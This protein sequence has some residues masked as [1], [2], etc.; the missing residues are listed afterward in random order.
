M[1]KR[2]YPLEQI[3]EIKKRRLEE[4]EKVL[5]EKRLALDNAEKDLQ[6]KRDALNASLQLK[7]DLIEKHFKE[8]EKGTTSDV[9]ERHNRY[10]QEVI[11]VKLA[12]EKKKV[13]DQKKVVKDAKLALEKARDIR[14]KK[15]QEM[16]KINIHKK[17]WTK[18]AVKEQEIEEAGIADELGTSMH[19]RKM[20][21]RVR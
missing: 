15:N 21:K 16:E 18:E 11:E 4:A 7:L 5:R 9:M 6:T 14:L 12:D 20:K 8:I 17:E 2:I 19:A 1:K 3:A 13:E 10:I